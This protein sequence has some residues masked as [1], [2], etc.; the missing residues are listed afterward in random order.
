MAHRVLRRAIRD[1]GADEEP[2]GVI[3]EIVASR[4]PA[5]VLIDC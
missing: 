2:D 4:A 1:L 5:L 3:I